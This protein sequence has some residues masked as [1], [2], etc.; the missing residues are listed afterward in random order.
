MKKLLP[1][2]KLYDKIIYGLELYFVPILNLVMRYTMFKIFFNSGWLKFMSWV[3][4]DWETT[5][6]LF[7]Y[8]HPVPFLSPEFAA[9]IGTANEV[10]FSILLLMGLATRPAAF[11]L[12]IMTL[13][14]EFT[15][16]SSPDHVLW[17]FL[18]INLILRGPSKLS[19]DHLMKKYISKCIK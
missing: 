1:L 5:I 18:L 4:D 19:V 14:I 9:V 11:V 6:M 16:T 8:E 2:I 13:V 7:T 3:N 10:I 15:Y 12:L 17:M